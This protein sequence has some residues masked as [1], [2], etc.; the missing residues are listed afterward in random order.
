MFDSIPIQVH[1][2]E[3]IISQVY[4]AKCLGVYYDR[5]MT[6]RLRIIP[7][8]MRGAQA[9]GLLHKCS[10]LKTAI[11]RSTL[12]LLYKAYP[13]STL[14][15]GCV[16]ILGLAFYRLRLLALLERPAPWLRLGL[17]KYVAN[18]F[19]FPETMSY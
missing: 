1:F 6:W 17:P 14:E 18:N 11:G 12:F 19:L 5:H 7:T 16:V 9:L 2:G 3:I 15:F 10:H 13:L 8:V 4:Q